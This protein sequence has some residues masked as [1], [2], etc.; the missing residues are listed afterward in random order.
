MPFCFKANTQK[1]KGNGFLNRLVGREPENSKIENLQMFA[2]FCR[3]LRKFADFCENFADFCE[4][5]QIFAKICK[6]SRKCEDFREN[7]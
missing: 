7:P 3:F 5:L 2:K 6:F 4:N 1:F